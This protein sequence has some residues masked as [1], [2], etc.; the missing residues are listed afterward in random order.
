[1]LRRWWNALKQ[2]GQARVDVSDKVVVGFVGFGLLVVGS[3]GIFVGASDMGSTAAIV[4]GAGM[5]VVA[6]MVDRILMIKV[7][8]YE[9]HLAKNLL[10][11]AEV[12]D[13][14]G[15]EPEADALR[16]SGM[17][18]LRQA[19]AGGVTPATAIRKLYRMARR[20]LEE[21]IGRALEAEGLSVEPRGLESLLTYFS[22]IGVRDD[23][24]VGVIISLGEWDHEAAARKI[25]MSLHGMTGLKG[26]VVV[27][28]MMG[29]R[30]MGLPEPST[31]DIERV[32]ENQLQGRVKV[33][34]VHWR[35]GD[36]MDAIRK[37]VAEILK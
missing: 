19:E 11:A 3:V 6:A 21:V 36:P 5:F 9:F 20:N 33:R 34:L 18:I 23:E 15:D 32:V 8:D 1:M 4:A 17:N 14:Q 16:A 7:R 28:E 10:E 35:Q 30:R 26:V 2:F 37:A 29:L 13:E 22:M 12:A 24:R 31:A 25:N 27:Q